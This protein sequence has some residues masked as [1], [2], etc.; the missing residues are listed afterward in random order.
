MHILC[1]ILKYKISQKCEKI[2]K[3]SK[4]FKYFSCFFIKKKRN[5]LKNMN[6]H[7]N[8]KCTY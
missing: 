6:L 4:I 7:K 5:V 8:W 3:I 1:E 2:C